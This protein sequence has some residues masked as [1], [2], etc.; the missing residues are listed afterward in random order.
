MYPLR[1]FQ[2][3]NDVFKM[4]ISLINHD[5]NG[6]RLAEPN[7]DPLKPYPNFTYFN[8]TIIMNLLKFVLKAIHPC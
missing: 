7:N 3:K 2:F 8:M 6:K 1:H 5:S 4:Q